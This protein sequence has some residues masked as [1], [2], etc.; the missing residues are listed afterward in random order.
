[1]STTCLPIWPTIL[2]N[3]LQLKDLKT[4]V[5]SILKHSLS[6]IMLIKLEEK[7]SDILWTFVLDRDMATVKV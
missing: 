5:V 4:L 2:I 3:N 7:I 1:M 6:H